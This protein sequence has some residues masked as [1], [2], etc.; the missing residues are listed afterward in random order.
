MTKQ[1]LLNALEEGLRTEE[2]ALPIY[3]KHIDSTLFLSGFTPEQQ[4]RI[5]QILNRL[6]TES[7]GH[8]RIYQNL[9]EKITSENK[10]VY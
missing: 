7:T 1:E 4:D 2:S 10:D 5:R 8:A 9:I 3:T 6:S